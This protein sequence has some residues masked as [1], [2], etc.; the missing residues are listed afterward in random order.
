[1]LPADSS[2]QAQPAEQLSGTLSASSTPFK[3]ALL[4]KLAL[5]GFINL[6]L[7]VALMAWVDPYALLSNDLRY[8]ELPNFPLYQYNLIKPWE[9]LDAGFLGSSS[10]NYIPMQ[11]L[12]PTDQKLFSMGIESSNIYEHVAYGRVLASK[13]PREI[14]F[15]VTFYAL[16]P[17][18]GNQ[19]YFRP[20]VVAWHQTAID[21]WAQY[22]NPQAVLDAWATLVRA[23]QHQP[24]QQEFNVDGSRTQNFYKRDATYQFDKTVADYLSWL[25]LDPRYYA[26]RTFRDPPSIAPGIQVIRDFRDELRR[27]GIRLRVVSCPEQRNSV[28]LLYAMGLGPTY[29]AYRKALADIQPFDDPNLDLALTATP[30]T[31]WDTHHVRQGWRVIDDLRLG[32][33]RVTPD[34]VDQTSVALRPTPQEFADLKRRLTTYTDW[35]KT[36][37]AVARDLK[38]NPPQAP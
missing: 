21:F 31:Y 6:L 11:G 20:N 29:E 10:V 16:N 9:Q 32:R 37:Q 3:H 33:Y 30:G 1:M 18:R 25:S 34:N 4:I 12:F 19:T 26:S 13:H 14:V 22:G 28:V 2:L 38:N 23:W 36:R 15:F 8:K 24:C 5:S 27:Q 7:Y 35:P 17:S